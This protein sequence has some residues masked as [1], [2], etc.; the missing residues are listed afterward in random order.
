M[1]ISSLSFRRQQLN[2]NLLNTGGMSNTL[3]FQ[4]DRVAF[5]FFFKFFNAVGGKIPVFF[6]TQNQRRKKFFFL[7]GNEQLKYIKD[8]TVHGSVLRDG[9]GIRQN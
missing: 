4:F 8:S 5:F 7:L 9:I 6:P 1:N 2:I 3:R